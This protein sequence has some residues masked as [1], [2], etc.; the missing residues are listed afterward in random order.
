MDRVEHDLSDDQ[1]TALKCGVGWPRVLR[2]HCRPLPRDCVLA[3]SRGGRST[4]DNIVPA[5]RSCSPTKRNDEV[6][7]W[8]RHEYLDERALVLRQRDIQTALGQR[9]SHRT[10]DAGD[11][12]PVD[13]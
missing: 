5:C 11:D 6:T 9:L 12:R 10:I 8:L 7:S 4:L 3:L 13:G 2:G 1:W